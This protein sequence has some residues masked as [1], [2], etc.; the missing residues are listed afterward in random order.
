MVYIII[1]T[2]PSGEEYIDRVFSDESLAK[3]WMARKADPDKYHLVMELAYG[4]E[5]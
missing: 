1:Y 5:K 2:A 3:D 4:K